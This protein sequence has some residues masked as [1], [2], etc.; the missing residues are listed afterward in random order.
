MERAIALKSTWS[1]ICASLSKKV[2]IEYKLVLK[3]LQ[4]SKVPTV[5]VLFYILLYFEFIQSR[6]TLERIYNVVIVFQFTY[7]LSVKILEFTTLT[8]SAY[9]LV[10]CKNEPL[11]T[12]F[13]K[14]LIYITTACL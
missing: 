7:I 8:S 14:H 11:G 2:I 3:V 12:N 6:N 4:V 9:G 10:Q 1:E 13:A 5:L